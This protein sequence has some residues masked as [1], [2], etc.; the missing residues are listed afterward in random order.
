MMLVI[1][2]RGL[3][4]IAADISETMRLMRLN[5]LNHAM[6]MTETP[7]NLGMLR[8]AKDYI[9]WGE[10]D[11]KTLE[12]MLAKRA[13][14]PGDN[15]VTDTYVAATT[16]YKTIKDLAAALLAGEATLEDAGIK[17]V[18]RLHPA[19]KGHEGIKR[20]FKEGGALGYRGAKINE[21]AQRMI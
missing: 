14:L 19:K 11:A 16:K 17:P 7:S 21:I 2:I 6:L 12:A 4:A 10:L 1:R 9:T 8:K 18:F 15:K 5:R 13:R 20:T 3:L